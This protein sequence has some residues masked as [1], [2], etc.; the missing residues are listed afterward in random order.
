MRSRANGVITRCRGRATTSVRGRRAFAGDPAA[1]RRG[2]PVP[3][4]SDHFAVTGERAAAHDIATRAAGGDLGCDATL[5]R[6]EE[7]FA[8]AIAHV[9]NLLDPDVIVLGGGL[10]NVDRLYANVPK[11]WGRWVFSD[12]V[13]TRL[14]RNVHGDSS[15]VRGAAW[16]WGGA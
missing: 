14:L 16:L 7:R 2:C 5:S 1:S 8:R 10:S 4:S 9:I 11:H 12:R 15:G 13:D 3:A 6:Y